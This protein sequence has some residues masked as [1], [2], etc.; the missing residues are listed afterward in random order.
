MQKIILMLCTT[1]YASF[2]LAQEVN[3][4]NY[5]ATH[6]C[7]H[8]EDEKVTDFLTFIDTPENLEETQGALQGMLP[9]FSLRDNRTQGFVF[10]QTTSQELKK[11]AIKG[12]YLFEAEYLIP[13]A[14]KPNLSQPAENS[15]LARAPET[16][17][18]ADTLWGAFMATG[19][20]VYVDNIL[21]ALKEGQPP[22]L[23]AAIQWSV[24]KNIHIYKKVRKRVQQHLDPQNP[25]Q[26][27]IQK[28][29]DTYQRN[30][31]SPL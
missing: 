21:A 26:H 22:L 15:L 24:E 3:T 30:I 6:F 20:V 10:S 16:P 4:W 1:F 7:E 8:Q 23:T 13:Q 27:H 25:N 18:E 31:Q 28:I 11:L 29:W 17:E 2:A 12:L 19:K 9:H 14:Y 5:W